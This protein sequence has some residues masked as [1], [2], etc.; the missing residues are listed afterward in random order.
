MQYSLE[1]YLFN[2]CYVKIS[3]LCAPAE[4]KTDM[5]K[6]SRQFKKISNVQRATICQEGTQSNGRER[7]AVQLDYHRCVYILSG[8][9]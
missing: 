6:M 5:V 2:A 1:K 4:G 9:I 7:N 8:T 3:V